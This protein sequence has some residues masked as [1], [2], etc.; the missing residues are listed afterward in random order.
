M[1]KKIPFAT[2][3]SSAHQ[4][5]G[6]FKIYNS[7][8]IYLLLI[9]GFTAGC[10]KDEFKEEITGV[11]PVVVSTDPADKAVDV[12]LEKLIS[13]TFNTDMD[14]ATIN[15][16]TFTIKQGSTLIA[17]TVAATGSAKTFTFDPDVDLLPF[18]E[19]TGT[20]TTGA[21]DPLHTAMIS[22]YVWTFTTIPALTVLANPV[23]NA[24]GGTVEGAGKFA[25]ASAVTVKATPLPGYFFVNWTETGAIVATT[26]IYPFPMAGNRTLIANFS[27]IPK[28]T[29]AVS[30]TPAAGGTASGNIIVETGTSVTAT[31]TVKSGYTFV[32]WTEGGVEVSKALAY[33]FPLTANRTLVANF[34]AIQFTLTLSANPALGGTTTGGGIFDT[35][36]SLTA[37]ATAQ[38]GYTFVNWTENNTSVSTN[39]NYPLVLTGDRTL[40][41]NFKVNQ[42]T[43]G[44]SA[45]PTAGGSTTGA[46]TFDPGTSVTATASAANG[47]TFVNWTEGGA[48]VSTNATYTFTITANRT[49]EAN[50][51]AV[52]IE[53]FTL[54]LSALPAASGTTTGGG[55]FD[56]GTSVTAMAT[57]NAG[58]S[59]VNWTENGAP[60]STNAS[61]PFQLN[62][63]RNLVANFIPTPLPGQFVVALSSNP[64]PGGTTTGGGPYNTGASVTVGATPN[65]NY[66][67][68]N[69][70]EN[71]VEVSNTATFTFLIAADRTLVAN[72]APVIIPVN[73]T[74]QV[75]AQNGNVVKN[76]D[77]PFYL[78][79]T[80]VQ[81]T[82]TANAGYVFTGWSGDAIG[83]ANPTT[84]MM[85]S[86]KMVTANF[87]L[88]PVNPP[89]GPVL[90]SLG[91]ADNFVILS[92]AGI[93]NVSNSIITGNVGTGPITGA[94]ITGLSCPEVVGTIYTIDAAG[95][96]CRVVDK[97]T[98]DNAIFDMETAFNTANGLTT[99]APIVEYATGILNG[100]I[101]A[102]GLYKWGTSVTIT[103]EL[104]L[105]GGAN[106]TWVFQISQ[107][108]V[109][110]NSTIIKL[111]GGAQAKN[112][113]WVVTG[114][115]TLGTSADFS[116]IILSKTLISLQNSAK[117]KGKLL[118]QTEVTLIMNAVTKP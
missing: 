28:F 21:K 93:T 45:K 37:V 62:G 8:W 26:A 13:A 35:G 44:L 9:A 55:L 46:G 87:A 74:L 65:L 32:N 73:Y 51:A 53:K 50:F 77:L 41:A 76:Q 27:P 84:V 34:K 18:K 91:G 70:T 69:W 17:G 114:K 25:Q 49:L 58:F 95:P 67:F 20:I 2:D 88:A 5:R 52:V 47:Y 19:Y 59:F 61:Y 36:S 101:L 100:Q 6:Y 40:V 10:Q 96:A 99:P 118:A 1:S 97:T 79:G 117:V 115:A 111:T 108:L 104:T 75:N 89:V 102:P 63:N 43:L 54:G 83:T 66:T 12:V 81:L 3:S 105:N 80:S 23:G 72:F 86:N 64:L 29:L 94:A 113:L 110:N 98:V 11:C 107:D 39:P 116:G 68:V 38:A 15:K 14:P 112:I 85:N 78:P 30:A 24:A 31:A 7:L 109:V 33:S 48:P 22:N 90:P 106:D 42:V 92:K 60:V 57:A 4:G 71:G 16:T 82:A 56:A 103:D